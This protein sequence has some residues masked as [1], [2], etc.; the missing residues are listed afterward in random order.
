MF[1]LMLVNSSKKSELLI[2]ITILLKVGATKRS[3][4]SLERKYNTLYIARQTT[5]NNQKTLLILI[6]QKSTSRMKNFI[7]LA[8][9]L[10]AGQFVRPF[11]TSTAPLSHKKASTDRLV[12]PHY[13]CHHQYLLPSTRWQ[14]P[15]GDV[16]RRICI[17]DS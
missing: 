10:A 2:Q 16:N 15:R 1:N 11:R 9:L 5:T 12:A 14:H 8:L 3:G 17:L 6:N 13:C 4:L 7:N